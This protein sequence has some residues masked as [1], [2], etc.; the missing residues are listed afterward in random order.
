MLKKISDLF[1]E[2]AISKQL[3]NYRNKQSITQIGTEVHI[4]YN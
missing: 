1:F 3:C 2:V 4:E